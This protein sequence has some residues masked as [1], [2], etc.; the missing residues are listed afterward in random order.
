MEALWTKA[1]RH[2]ANE[3]THVHSLL[4]FDCVANWDCSCYTAHVS[5]SLAAILSLISDFISQSCGIS[6]GIPRP[7]SRRDYNSVPGNC[8]VC[9]L[10]PDRKFCT[11]SHGRVEPRHG[12]TV[13]ATMRLS[14]A[15]LHHGLLWWAAI[16]GKVGSVNEI[17]WREWYFVW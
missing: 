11:D 15:G 14:V 2:E 10:L 16:S 12:L 1:S 8:H 5:F 3:A 7:A 9:T 4:S 13:R 17:C 6:I